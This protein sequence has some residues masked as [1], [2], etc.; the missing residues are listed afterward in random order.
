MSHRIQ[1]L[2]RSGCHL[3][4]DARRVVRAV[5]APQ[6]LTWQE[7]DVDS[8]GALAQQY[9]ELVPVVL[10]DDV[11]IGYFRIDPERLRRAVA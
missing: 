10:V 1:L 9:G 6:G 3:C 7:V 11:Q 2:G 8:D 4:D 5:C